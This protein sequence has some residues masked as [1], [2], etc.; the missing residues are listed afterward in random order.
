MK[1]FFVTVQGSILFVKR[2]ERFSPAASSSQV[3]VEEETS[4]LEKQ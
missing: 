3:R 2:G 4:V 1:V